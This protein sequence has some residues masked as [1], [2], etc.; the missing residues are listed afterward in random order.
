MAERD[1]SQFGLI[2]TTQT[3]VSLGLNTYREVKIALEQDFNVARV[4]RGVGSKTLGVNLE[5]QDGPVD[6][7]GD[8]IVQIY[9][10]FGAL[11]KSATETKTAG[12]TGEYT[13]AYSPPANAGLGIYKAVHSFTVSGS[14]GEVEEWMRIVANTPGDYSGT[15]IRGEETWSG[16]KNIVNSLGQNVDP[17]DNDVKYTLRSSRGVILVENA[18]A[19]RVGIGQYS[20][21]Y[22]PGHND[23]I[24]E[25][26][27]AFTYEINGTAG[28]CETFF[29][30]SERKSEL[31]VAASEFK[32]SA[33][34]KGIASSLSGWSDE[35]ID[36]ALAD[37]QDRVEAWTGISLGKKVITGERK[38]GK[39]TDKN[40]M[41]VQLDNAPIYK[42]IR[43]LL[44]VEPTLDPINL[45]VSGCEIYHNAGQIEY[46][47]QAV[48]DIE[49]TIDNITA[50]DNLYESGELIIDYECG[51]DEVPR[52]AKVAV[53]T[54]AASSIRKA[55][56]DSD[57]KMIQSGNHKVQYQDNGSSGGS[58][59]SR[60][61]QRAFDI[62]KMAGLVNPPIA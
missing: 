33:E 50:L 44:K 21:S 27:V 49:T 17:D 15:I 58:S 8:V 12:A 56:G 22:A 20:A 37:A 26:S 48:G 61:E 9:D 11:V 55:S 32:S 53:R 28:S 23:P 10:S 16:T 1:I 47:T 3:S 18:Q 6:A 51:Y 14:G 30:V 34:G 2:A 38:T 29:N 39:M 46:S 25:Y 31:A 45:P 40:R 41:F 42:L 7:D 5:D 57:V 62:L 35:E 13:Y 52:A 43:V 36:E 4:V 59:M 24:G 60:D 19:T 54:L